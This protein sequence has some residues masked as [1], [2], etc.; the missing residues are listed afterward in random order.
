ML[1]SEVMGSF[2][3]R[4]YDKFSSDGELLLSWGEK[5]KNIKQFDLPHSVWVDKYERVWVADRMNDRIQIF[6]TEGE[7]IKQ[8]T[9]FMI[10][11]LGI[12]FLKGENPLLIKSTSAYSPSPMHTASILDLSR[13]FHSK[14][15]RKTIY[16]LSLKQT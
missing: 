5:G 4:T 9:D 10:L 15:G 3:H 2:L 8:I 12:I 6:T 11:L 1:I 7:Y 13:L 14:V 16:L